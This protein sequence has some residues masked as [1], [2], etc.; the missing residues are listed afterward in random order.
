MVFPYIDSYLKFGIYIGKALFFLAR[1][2]NIL[3]YHFILVPWLIPTNLSYS[4]GAVDMVGFRGKLNPPPLNP[5]HIGGKYFIIVLVWGYL[6]GGGG[7]WAMSLLF[8]FELQFIYL[9][10]F[11]LSVFVSICLFPYLSNPCYLP[12]GICSFS[13][14]TVQHSINIVRKMRRKWIIFQISNLF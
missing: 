13:F 10:S 6:Y 12:E 11:F 2:Q 5:T 4:G 8:G 3:S 14:F 1:A 7:L 9:L